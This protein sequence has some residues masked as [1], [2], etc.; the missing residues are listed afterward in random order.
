APGPFFLG[1]EIRGCQPPDDGERRH[2]TFHGDLLVS[3]RGSVNALS[4]GDA[5]VAVGSAAVPVRNSEPL[6]RRRLT[7]ALP[8]L[9]KRNPTGGG[10]GRWNGRHQDQGSRN[11]AA[12]TLRAGR[13][14]KAALR[15][16][17]RLWNGGSQIMT[18]LGIRGRRPRFISRHVPHELGAREGAE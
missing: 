8:P 14:G 13:S 15:H 11:A 1:K 6:G 7:T 4:P 2:E 3:A 12:F 18:F 16:G 5:N 17:T 9:A 10:G